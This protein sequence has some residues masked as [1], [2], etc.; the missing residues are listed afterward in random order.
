[1]R[2]LQISF[3]GDHLSKVDRLETL[4]W[5][6]FVARLTTKV[7]TTADKTSAGW[8]AC[9]AYTDNYRDEEHL[10]GRECLTF[11]FDHITPEDAEKILH[12]YA[13]FEYLIYTTHSHKKDN[14]RLR[15]LMPLS[16]PCTPDEFRAISRA[17][18]DLVGIELV[19]PESHKPAQI[20]FMPAMPPGARFKSQRNVGSWVDVD[21]TLALYKDWTDR[22]SWPVAKNDT[23]YKSD[24]LPVPA[25][26]KPGI[27]GAFNRVYSITR[28]IEEFGLPYEKV[29]ETRWTYTKG[30]RPEGA[31]TYDDDTKLHSENATDPARGQHS[32]FDLV[33]L[34][35]FGRLD[36]NDLDEGGS[37]ITERP[38]FR[39]MV[40]FAD[41]IAEVRTE[42]AAH[43]LDSLPP[44][45]SD[46]RVAHD[47]IRARLP[48][49]E[50]QAAAFTEVSSG[51]SGEAA[52]S[53]ATAAGE[54]DPAGSGSA[55]GT[56]EPSVGLARPLA[57]VVAQRTKPR[58]LIKD[59]LERG[60]V[61]LLIGQR[62]SYKSFKALDWACRI[63]RMGH[64]VYVV[65]AE[66][67]DFDRRASAWLKTHA[68]G[69]TL[70]LY[71]VERRL[72]LGKHEGIELIRQDCVRLGIRPVLFVLDTFS[73]LSGGLDENDNSEVKAFI[74]RLD[75]GLKRADT[76]FD[77]TVLVVAHTGHS[78]K[79][80]ARGASAIGADTDAEYIVRRLD[81]GKT[82]VLVTRERFKASPELPPLA[83]EPKI[84]QLGYSDDEGAP[85][86]SVVLTPIEQTGVPPSKELRPEHREALAIVYNVLAEGDAEYEDLIAALVHDMPPPVEVDG[87]KQRDTRVQIARRRFEVLE[88][89][90]YVRRRRGIGTNIVSRTSATETDSF[91]DV[92]DDE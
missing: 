2:P 16:R 51:G 56:T 30:S 68:P 18:A 28:A 36:G 87:K 83:Y 33:R 3:G 1:M 57:E 76:G 72:D 90:G 10:V 60:V 82:T 23:T 88:N 38:S 34:H 84:I 4:T 92:K 24:E 65:S 41:S 80:R 6:E 12:V 22:K 66:G 73:K 63:A 89:R 19:A 55:A 17:V 71:V 26:E 61:A 77:A 7:P 43:G 46:E 78:D 40:D 32:A 75:N 50:I 74:G 58:W 67:G 48:S 52:S 13:S 29:S 85:V 91:D 35:R 27:I 15:L 44:L 62:G 53:E 25:R 86:T 70:P 39:A 81:N 31:R 45:T 21:G 69:E 20:M 37:P 79:G 8:Y 47:R 54:A 11:D 5:D 42:S 9:T 49:G 64:A 14:P 59:E